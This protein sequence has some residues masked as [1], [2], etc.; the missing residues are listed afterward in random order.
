VNSSIELRKVIG[1]V[2]LTVLWVCTFLFIQSTLVIDWVGDGSVTTNFKFVVV[3]IGLLIII[4]Y[5]IFYRASA[6]TTKLSLT[7][8]LTI[9]WLA[10][11]IF[12]PFK[13]PA[14]DAGGAVAFFALIGGLGIVVLWVRFFSD[15][16]V[17]SQS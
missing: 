5:H 10:L 17:V 2:V 15:D 11:I 1:G 9:C 6:E 14:N 16:I 8:A 4:L 13:D 3:L 12:Y 7:T